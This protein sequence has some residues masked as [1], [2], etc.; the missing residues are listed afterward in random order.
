MGRRETGKQA[1]LRVRDKL[2]LL[3]LVVEKPEGDRGIRLETHA[4]GNR[5]RHALIQVKGRNPEKD[6][7]LRWFQIRVSGKELKRAKEQ[8]WPPDQTWK[9]KVQEVDFF[10]LVALRVDEIWVLTRPR[11]HE[12]IRLNEFR[13][14][15]RPDNDFAYETPQK[16]R[17]KEMNLDIE[18]N[19]EVLTSR[20][21]DCKDNFDPIL[22]YLGVSSS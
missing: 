7:N 13:Y 8:G 16:Y 17:Q 2:E 12:L 9:D 4:P 11:V 1:E 10:V 21:Q 6:P 20:F 19:R 5:S 15:S 22:A 14:G 18:V 3:R